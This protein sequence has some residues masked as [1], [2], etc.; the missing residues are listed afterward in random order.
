MSGRSKKADNLV[1]V[2][3]KVFNNTQVGLFKILH[4]H[5]FLYDQGQQSLIRMGWPPSLCLP[6]V[7][8]I[9]ERSEM[10]LEGAIRAQDEVKDKNKKKGSCLDARACQSQ[11]TWWL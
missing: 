10:K 7:S 11:G 1:K 8:E 4:K 3:W 5:L 2:N 9:Y 6:L